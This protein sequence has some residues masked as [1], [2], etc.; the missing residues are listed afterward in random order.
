M[1]I[2]KQAPEIPIITEIRDLNNFSFLF[3]SESEIQIYRNLGYS[4]CPTFTNGLIFISN[5]VDSLA[6]QSHFNNAILDV[7]QSLLQGSFY[8]ENNKKK[9]R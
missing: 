6:V 3:R 2:K 4:F 8:E 7:M 9:Q 1:V 5:M